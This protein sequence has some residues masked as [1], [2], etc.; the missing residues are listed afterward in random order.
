MMT[1]PL[2]A[3]EA[4]NRPPHTPEGQG[5][6]S[7]MWEWVIWDTSILQFFTILAI[8]RPLWNR[9]ED[10][11]QPKSPVKVPLNFREEHVEL[12]RNE[13][14]DSTPRSGAVGGSRFLGS[15][16]CIFLELRE[17][18]SLKLANDLLREES[19]IHP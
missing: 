9:N 5:R 4:S 7:L 3:K 14:S 16:N 12:Y 18:T 13:M 8:F 2:H 19:P 17:S 15:V 10:P 6:A 1:G 11:E